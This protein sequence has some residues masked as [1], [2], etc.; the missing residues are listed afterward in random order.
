MKRANFLLFLMALLIALPTWAEE[1]KA[2][3]P[4]PKAAY[5]ALQPSIVVNLAKGA[6]YARFEVQLMIVDAE[7]LDKVKPHVPALVNEMLLQISDEDGASLKTPD[8][9]ESFRKKC[10]DASNKLLTELAKVE[11]PVKDLFFTTFYVK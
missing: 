11:K 9:K 1:E 3:E 7:T 5:L 2:A 4:P 10:L 6:K 8:G